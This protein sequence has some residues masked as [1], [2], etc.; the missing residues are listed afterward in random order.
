MQEKNVTIDGEFVAKYFKYFLQLKN[1][2]VVYKLPVERVSSKSMYVK[3][4]LAFDKF[5]K[6][7][8]KYSIDA[9]KLLDFYVNKLNKFEK[10]VDNSLVAID[11]INKYVESLQIAD[12]HD[13]IYKNFLKSVNNIVADCIELNFNSVIDYLRYLISNRKLAAYYA[14]GKISTYYF[15]AIPKFRNVIDK[16]D[17]LAKAEFKTL[18]DRYEKYHSDVN[19]AFLKMKNIRI[20]P[21]KFTNDAILKARNV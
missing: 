21:I 17:D 2:Y 6:I 4:K 15:A 13:K 5:A 9:V 11:T 3:H 19:E 20:N 7:C 14:T 10:D 12:L 16:L 1:P 8:S 18:Y